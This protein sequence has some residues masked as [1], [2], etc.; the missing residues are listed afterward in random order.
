MRQGFDEATGFDLHGFPNLDNQAI[1]GHINLDHLSI[2]CLPMKSSF[3]VRPVYFIALLICIESRSE[4]GEH[5]DI[6]VPPCPLS[7][8]VRVAR[9]IMNEATVYFGSVRHSLQEEAFLKSR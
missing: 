1:L 8:E 5:A 9:V 2:S 3:W 4:A 7:S 6:L